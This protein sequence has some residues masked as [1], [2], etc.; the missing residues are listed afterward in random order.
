[1]NYKNLALMMLLLPITSLG[2]SN[3]ARIKELEEAQFNMEK[4]IINLGD[5]LEHAHIAYYK[6]RNKALKLWNTSRNINKEDSFEK[7]INKIG[8]AFYASEDINPMI[9][10]GAF[11][12]E[13]YHDFYIIITK[14]V[15]Q[16]LHIG[17][18]TD[19]FKNY[20]Q[21]LAVIIK[22]LNDLKKN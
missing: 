12:K 22:N 2:S 17:S 14:M 16:R 4:E 21:K 18:I 9:E 13:D 10:E 5:E 1:M 11:Y 6:D 19:K 7:F 8:K 20:I 3:E 15:V